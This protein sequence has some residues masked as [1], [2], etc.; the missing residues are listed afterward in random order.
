MQIDELAERN[1]LDRAQ[2]EFQVLG[3]THAELGAALMKQWGF[4]E[5]LNC[6][7][8]CSVDLPVEPAE[9][10]CPANRRKRNTRDAVT[11]P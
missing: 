11:Y 9:R 10:V 8:G 4:P 6:C 5:L 7:T 1:R 2:A 3:F